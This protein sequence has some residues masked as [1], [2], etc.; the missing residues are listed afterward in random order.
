MT[1]TQ[2]WR[3]QD[4]YEGY[5]CEHGTLTIEEYQLACANFVVYDVDGDGTISREDFK[6]AMI[7]HSAQWADPDKAEQLEQMF[8]GVDV[9]R[10]RSAL[11]RLKSCVKCRALLAAPALPFPC[12][13]RTPLDLSSPRRLAVQWQRRGDVR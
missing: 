12:I 11:V 8:A 9:R 2:R 7:K 1:E 10:G 6:Q 13:S 3:M 5:T 4:A